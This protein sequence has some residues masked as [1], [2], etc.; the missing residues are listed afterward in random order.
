MQNFTSELRNS[1]RTVRK[2]PGFT[3]I[4]IL[5]LALG[6]GA[7]T[8][9][10]SIVHAVLIQPLPFPEF[11]KLVRLWEID[12]TA[13]ADLKMTSV[14]NL[15]DWRERNRTLEGIAAW[16]RP[17]SMT[18]TSQVPAKEID[19][20]SVTANFF[21]VLKTDASLGR[22]FLDEEEKTTSNVAVLSHGF[23]QSH[24]ASSRAA[25]GSLIQLD[26]EKYR[27]VGVMP[28]HFRSPSGDAE[29]WIPL[30]LRANE[31]DRGQNY[32]QVLARLKQGVTD[33]QAR[34]D[35]DSIAAK[36]EKEYPSSNAREGIALIPMQQHLTSSLRTPLMILSIAVTLVLLISC[37]NIS[38][39][40]M[41]RAF[42]RKR[43][44]TLRM[45]L[46]ASKW[47]LFRQLLTEN[48]VL[49]IAG[50]AAGFLFA[51]WLVSMFLYLEPQILPGLI[52]VQVENESLVYTLVITTLAGLL[53][54]MSPAIHFQ[55]REIG[56]ALR[57]GRS[58]VAGGLGAMIRKILV[59][60]QI[61]FS[62]VLVVSA[63]LLV[64]S[65][66]RMSSVQPGFLANDIVVI[67]QALDGPKY[68]DPAKKSDYY[69]NLIAGL[70]E[71]PGVRNAAAGTVIPM[72][73]FGID[74]EVPYHREDRPQR[75]PSLSPHASFRS[76]T[77]GY[78]E[79]LQ[80]ALLQGR[81]FSSDDDE[82]RPFAVIVNE[83]LARQ[84]WPGE[85]AVGKRLR[86][87]WA[88][89]QTY[90]VVG[91]VATTH[92]YGLLSDAVPELYVPDA[93]IPYSV[94]NVVVRFNQIHVDSASQIRDA[95]L[96]IDPLQPAQD[97]TTLK[98]LSDESTGRERFVAS[99]V[100]SF[101]FLGFILALAGVYGM[102][103]FDTVR[104][105]REIGLRMAL[106]ATRGEIRIWIL[107]KGSSLVLFGIAIGLCCAWVASTLLQKFLFGVQGNDP[108]TLLSASLSLFFAA[109]IACM[110]P[111]ERAASL[112]PNLALHYE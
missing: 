30:L 34:T 59:I 74:F 102:L 61:A 1:I 96:K 36:L 54:G 38:N 91:V 45:L 2:R 48:L 53:F 85:N 11:N 43:E 23:W 10:F 111:A 106:G 68:T 16:T 82:S 86:F 14:S 5:I 33:E 71:I 27:I 87:F 22:T 62:F 41:I 77:P 89:W 103:S 60:I 78:F 75:E 108:V 21:S 63:A 51:Q 8:A 81:P 19:A 76:V 29:I 50:G 47:R 100:G 66:I 97:I 20:V 58:A 4:I 26:E 18:L 28:E 79:T 55:D 69:Q 31:I 40:M 39:L 94:M 7:N 44:F 37:S 35:L 109:I 80:I 65:F 70:K 83:K 9:I 98:Q 3:A 104:R 72:G 52:T 90:Q 49:F 110:I 17:S 12:R 46:G 42:D 6:T 15:I 25:V 99:L 101:A 56:A 64:Q 107:K 73:K 93:Q 88:D 112:D 32:L 67:Q 95:F 13:R 84:A 57:E 92:S 24:F 105:T